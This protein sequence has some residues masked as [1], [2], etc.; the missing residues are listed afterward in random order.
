M[1]LIPNRSTAIVSVAEPVSLKHLHSASA[2]RLTSTKS[3]TSAI[4][5][6]Q[7]PTANIYDELDAT[8]LPLPSE[9]I[10]AV[11]ISLPQS[12]PARV[13]SESSGPPVLSTAHILAPPADVCIGVTQIPVVRRDRMIQTIDNAKE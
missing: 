3:S 10:A 8:L 12:R 7:T 13:F 1:S 11:F 4:A 5:P 6:S 9:L 2:T